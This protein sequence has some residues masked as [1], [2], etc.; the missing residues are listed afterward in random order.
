LT[1][2]RIA[3]LKRKASEK[4]DVQ[5]TITEVTLPDAE[6]LTKACRRC[7][8][9]TV[10]HQPSNGSCL[11]CELV[12]GS[13]AAARPIEPDEPTVPAFAH[14]SAD[15]V[16]DGT[17]DA[18]RADLES[19]QV[20]ENGEVV[21]VREPGGLA[22][23]VE[24]DTERRYEDLAK[25]GFQRVPYKN[26][27]AYEPDRE[28]TKA[29]RDRAYLGDKSTRSLMTHPTAKGGKVGSK[30]KSRR[31]EKPGDHAKV[32]HGVDLSPEKLEPTRF[33]VGGLTRG[34]VEF[35]HAHP[36]VARAVLENFAQ[37]IIRQTT[38]AI[39]TG[40]SF[41]APDLPKIP[42]QRTK[43]KTKGK[44]KRSFE[45]YGLSEVHL[46]I[47]KAM[48]G[49]AKLQLI[50]HAHEVDGARIRLRDAA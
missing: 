22:K 48:R 12:G 16:I 10:A 32:E 31:S 21:D 41:E 1:S 25:N 23:F 30:S 2:A 44:T 19:E 20:D 8:H 28:P 36:G 26:A 33:N 9:A 24:A 6:V 29:E 45:I 27:G 40:A 4:M 46:E 34:E 38:K 5:D 49:V 7:D 15:Y 37:R 13:C 17:D 47:L 14:A 3:A 11:T 18:W 42:D 50:S 43:G 35:Y 39:E